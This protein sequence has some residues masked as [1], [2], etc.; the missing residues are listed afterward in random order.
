MRVFF[1]AAAAETV[2]DTR[3]AAKD[4]LGK[5]QKE[6]KEVCVSCRFT[7]LSL[8]VPFHILDFSFLQLPVFFFYLF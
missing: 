4:R 1:F 6:A 5:F 8:T 2:V 7:S 3:D